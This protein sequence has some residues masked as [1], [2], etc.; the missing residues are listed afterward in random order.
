MRVNERIA[1]EDKKRRV[2]KTVAASV[3]ESFEP[4][5]PIKIVTAS[6]NQHGSSHLNAMH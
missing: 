5:E 2:K 3:T 6:L 1:I 4:F